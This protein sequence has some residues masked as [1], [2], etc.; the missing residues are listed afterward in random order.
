MFFF[1]GKPILQSVKI[2]KIII[3]SELINK[4]R[5]VEK[6]ISEKSKEHKAP[7]GRKYKSSVETRICVYEW[8]NEHHPTHAIEATV[9]KDFVVVDNSFAFIENF[10]LVERQSSEETTAHITCAKDEIEKR[11]DLFEKIWNSY[12]KTFLL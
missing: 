5:D 1:F 2:I 12:T 4:I 9:L 11:K 6:D 7:D 10:T 3:I 8:L